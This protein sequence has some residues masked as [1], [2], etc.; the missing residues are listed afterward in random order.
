MKKLLLFAL[1]LFTL[2]AFTQQRYV[3]VNGTS[4]LEVNADE[5]RF[6]VQIRTI[7]ASLESSKKKADQYAA[8]LIRLLK[9]EGINKDN[10]KESPVTFGKNYDYSEGKRVQKGFFT[11]INV[12]FLLK[13]FNKYY[14]LT[15]KISTNENYE[16]NS[17]YDLS[18]LE[19][20]NRKA[21]EQA[22]LAAKEKA[23]YLCNT[24]GVTLG[25]VL[26]IDE[27]GN[28][29]NNPVPFNVRSKEFTPADNPFG[30]VTIQKS[31]RV[32]FGIK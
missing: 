14:E 30:T 18:D 19:K 6:N 27:T 1:M 13:E 4:E 15:D 29:R 16:M 28:D 24:L 12:S 23:E 10:I 20:Q 31:I 9:D 2:P 11:N 22:L 25:D 5:I 32:K 17:V 8:Q 3:D 21:Y 7:D 26:E